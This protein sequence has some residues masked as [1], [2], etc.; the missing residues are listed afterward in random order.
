MQCITSLFSVDNSLRCL[1][2]FYFSNRRHDSNEGR[3]WTQ[4]NRHEK[5]A[6]GTRGDTR[7]DE[8]D[9]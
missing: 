4:T 1:Y 6:G 2:S 5:T 9:I 7:Q 8:N 3:S